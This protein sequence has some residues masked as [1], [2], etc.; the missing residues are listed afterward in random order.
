MDTSRTRLGLILIGAL[1]AVPRIAAAQVSPVSFD[2]V[3]SADGDTGSQVARKPTAWIDLFGAVRLAEGLDLRVRPVF[4]RRS[5]DG[6][7]QTQ[8]YELALRYE[9]PG[10]VGVRA[11]VGQFSSPVGLSILE[12]RPDINP[13]ISQHSTL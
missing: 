6:R 1:A 11:D 7:W 5:F 12:N 3:V 10:K 9:R 13:V 2:A 8:M 4:L